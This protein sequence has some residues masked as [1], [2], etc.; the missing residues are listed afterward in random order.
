MCCALA[1]WAVLLT[2]CD[3]TPETIA[4]SDVPQIVGLENRHLSGLQRDGD[5]LVGARA[6]YRGEMIDPTEVAQPTIDRYLSHGWTLETKRVCNTSATL[7]FVKGQ[8]EVEVDLK[9]NH[10]NPAMGIGSIDVRRHGA[11]SPAAPPVPPAA[12][13][14]PTTAPPASV[15]VDGAS[16]S[17]GTS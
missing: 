13:P 17:G 5:T 1:A 3:S 11:A 4:E 15:P 9:S 8:R 16:H 10:L 6:L 14:V 12:A 7:L 2:G